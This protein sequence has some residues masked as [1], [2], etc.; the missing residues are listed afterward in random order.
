MSFQFI[1]DLVFQIVKSFPAS[2]FVFAVCA[3]NTKDFWN[4][5]YDMLN[6]Q[7]FNSYTILEQNWLTSYFL[8]HIGYLTGL[9]CLKNLINKTY[10]SDLD[11]KLYLN[12]II[13]NL[14]WHISPSVISDTLD[15]ASVSTTFTHSRLVSVST[16]SKF[17][18]LKESRSQ[19]LY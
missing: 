19:H 6:F 9:W 5:K 16:S 3:N 11:N 2:S 8:F 13:E 10:W 17:L 12:E 14:N 4:K 18:G 7:L 15:K 1:K